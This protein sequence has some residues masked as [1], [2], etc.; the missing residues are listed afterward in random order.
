M[1]RTVRLLLVVVGWPILLS[2]C[3]LPL[4]SP[5]SEAQAKP[6]GAFG[7]DAP[8]VSNISAP[9][10]A[11]QPDG[12]VLAAG[13]YGPQGS[14][15]DAEVYDASSN[16]WAALP[17]MPVARGG[18][19]ATTLPDGAIL[20]AGGASATGDPLA[21]AALFQ[22]N[23]GWT[24]TGPMSVPR[25]GHIALRL[26]D[27]RV[28]LL[29]GLSQQALFGQITL[30]TRGVDL[31]DP[32]TRRF[33][34]MASAP[35]VVQGAMFASLPDGRVL[36]AGGDDPDHGSTS[37]AWLFDPTAN[38]WTA[39]RSMPVS[40]AYGFAITLANGRV[41][42]AGGEQ[43]AA[44][45]SGSQPGMLAL[46][47]PLTSALLYDPIA[48]VW[49][50]IAD[51]PAAIQQVFGGALLLRDGRALTFVADFAGGSTADLSAVFYDPATGR[52]SKGS[53]ISVTT[54]GGISPTLLRSGTV[55]LVFG[56]KSLVFDPQALGPPPPPVHPLASP[57]LTPWLALVA[58]VLLLILT[59]QYAQA[60]LRSRRRPEVALHADIFPDESQRS[61][62]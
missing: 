37:R 30:P 57:Q 32:S 48:N 61:K 29:G 17:N 18:A 52:W 45:V 6:P 20:V 41:L 36:M 39:G 42:V 38:R 16:S 12:R 62:A 21:S 47:P 43:T 35:A 59:G 53:P 44:Q 10:L 2:A 51:A 25:S 60:Q 40:R 49:S 1:N 28:L 58:A 26:N 5:E 9:A 15:A 7:Q 31:F 22:P 54:N 23:A 11:L 14:G 8:M 33:T 13:G 56:S 55:L 19:T 4:V 34:P 46:G 50:T 24:P 3:A 27:G